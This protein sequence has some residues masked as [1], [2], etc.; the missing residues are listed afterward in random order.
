MGNTMNGEPWKIATHCCYC[1]FQ[2]GMKVHV[3]PETRRVVGVEG[4]EA[5]PVNRGQMCVKGQTSSELL[6]HPERL[7]YPLM[8]C[9][10]RFERVTWDDALQV[11]A[12]KLQKIQE[13]HGKP[14][15]GVYGGGALTNEKAYLLGKFAR[16]ALQ[17]PNIDY[18]GRFCMSCAA[19]ASI[20]T[21]GIDR[22]LTVPLSDI[23][24]AKC[25]LL[26]G[27]NLVETL[28]PLMQYLKEAKRHGCSFIV[29]DPRQSA[30]TK[31]A[32]MH[33]AIRPGTDLAL[34][35][36]LLCA[37]A[38]ENLLDIRFLTQRVRGFE[39][40][41]IAAREMT[42]AE[43]AETCGITPK[44]ILRAARLFGKAPTGMVLTA[45]GAEQHSK[46]TDTTC[47]YLNLL[48]ATGKIGRPGCGGGPLT[49]QGNGQGGR[50]HGQKAD[51]LPGYRKIDNPAHRAHIASVWGV[52]EEE[53]PGP[54]KSA[55]ELL[56]AVAQKEI[57]GLLV[58]GSNPAVSAPNAKHVN[59][60]LEGL[61]FLAVADF[62]LSETAQRADVVF[63]ATQWA[64]ED[65]TVTNLEGRV[66]L[67]R[68]ASDPPGEARSDT[69]LMLDLARRLGRGKYFPYNHTREIFEEL[70]I[71]TKGGTAD[72]NGITW[73]RIEQEDGVF[74]PCPDIRHPGTPRM[75]TERFET[76]DGKAQMQAVRYRPSA[77]EPD[78][79]FPL[80]LTT[81]RYLQHYLSGTQTRRIGA[82]VKVKPR[83]LVEI[84]P[85]TAKRYG[86]V[87][88]G[89]ARLT[90]RR[91]SV[92]LTVKLTATIRTDTL[93]A[94]FHWGE[95][96]TVNDLTNPA[97]DPTS[98]MPEFKTCAVRIESVA[99]TTR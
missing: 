67:R 10:D 97:L 9:G 2:C 7:R 41:L 96:Q 76:P 27:T 1:A 55:Y 39:E 83:P 11:T 23:P 95:E 22:G 28:P 77:E 54:G 19:A 60:G 30:T 24:R 93:F 46:G 74:W 92:V 34:A 59:R 81:G 91:G 6:Y 98:R 82:L 26:C 45:R 61:D 52:P 99:P 79:E 48:L 58:I 70:R 88:G 80:R 78:K 72:Y 89:K 69:L 40:A 21:F 50:E 85:E 35:N 32:D 47:S 73:G 37:L 65:G 49:G 90:T 16:L 38:D 29:I 8:R 86:L 66:I 64:E 5:F 42:I 4:N 43:A 15:V 94:P 68:R 84:H 33:L 44:E 14:A 71:A 18:N 57:R 20:K 53:I 62:F 31:T 12:E 3:D 75:F 17:T 25:I 63:P 51:Q 56:D 36:A 13:K 87:E